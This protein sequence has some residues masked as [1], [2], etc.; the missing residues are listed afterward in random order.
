MRTGA[1]PISLHYLLLAASL[2]GDYTNS[3]S[4]RGPDELERLRGILRDALRRYVKD[5]EGRGGS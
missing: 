5:R 2:A 4:F 3:L 1:A